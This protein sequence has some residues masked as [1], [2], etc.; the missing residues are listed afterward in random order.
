MIDVKELRVGNWVDRGDGDDYIDIREPDEIKHASLIGN[1][2]PLTPELLF[3]HGFM[4]VSNDFILPNGFTIKMVL[5][6]STDEVGITVKPNGY[7]LSVGF[8]IKPLEHLHQ[9]QNIYYDLMQTEL[10]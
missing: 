1:S 4:Q 2:I 9:L 5:V 7:I 6:E 3:K 8:P 10:P